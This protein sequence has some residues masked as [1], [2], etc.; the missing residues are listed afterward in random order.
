MLENASLELLSSKV[1][2]IAFLLQLQQFQKHY[3]I[4][5]SLLIFSGIGVKLLHKFTKKIK[6]KRKRMTKLSQRDANIVKH[7]QNLADVRKP[8]LMYLL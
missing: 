3:A 4:G 7:Q 8:V 6:L 5:I 1:K 2:D